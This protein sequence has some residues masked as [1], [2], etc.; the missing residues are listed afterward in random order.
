MGG[1]LW[2]GLGVVLVGAI[3]IG[4]PLLTVLILVFLG[5]YGIVSLV[6]S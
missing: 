6:K 1:I 5:L 4:S 3:L 2:M